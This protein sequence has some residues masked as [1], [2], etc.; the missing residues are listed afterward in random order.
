MS[1]FDDLARALADRSLSRRETLR[2]LGAEHCA[3]ADAPHENW[4][5]TSASRQAKSRTGRPRKTVGCM[6]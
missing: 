6:T 1:L 4:S 3:R 5:A 2:K